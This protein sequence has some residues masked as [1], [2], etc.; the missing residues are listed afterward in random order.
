[1]QHNLSLLVHGKHMSKNVRCRLERW[2]SIEGSS[3]TYFSLFAG[4]MAVELCRETIARS[5]LAVVFRIVGHRNT[6]RLS[7]RR[8]L[9]RDI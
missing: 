6:E 1:M 2:L 5:G 3:P 8:W 7:E 4:E 9:G